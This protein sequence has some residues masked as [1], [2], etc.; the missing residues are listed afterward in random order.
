MENNGLRKEIK[1]GGMIA[2]A[3]GGMVAAWMVEIKY[4]FE[5]GGVGSFL[6]LVACAIMVLPLCFIYSELTSMMPYAGGQNIWISNALGWNTGFAGCWAI[7]L[8]Y[9]MAMPTVSYGIA[10]MLGYIFPIT[11]MQLKIISIVIL[12]IFLLFLKQLSAI[13]VTL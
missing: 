2:M 6:S 12:V 11:N 8:L 13:F 9:V 10:S 4:W 3:A 7:L 5:I 1:L